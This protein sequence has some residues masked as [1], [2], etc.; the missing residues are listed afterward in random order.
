ME[1]LG[2]DIGGSGIKGAIVNTITGALISK[3]HRIPT[4]KPSNPALMGAVV[5]SLVEHF[6]WKGPVGCSFPTVIVDGK[7]RTEGNLSPGW[8]G[9]KLDDF[10]SEQCGGLQFYVGNDADLAGIAEM[11]LGAGKNKKGKVV[12]ITIG[13]GLGSGVFNNQ[14][15]VSNVELGRIFH[16]DGRPIEFFASDSAR[17][18]ERLSLKEWAKRFDFFLNHVDR[19]LSPNYFIIGGGLSKKFKEFKDDLT[20]DVPVEIA[21]FKNNAGIIGA[22]MFAM[23]NIE[24]G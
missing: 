14:K 17:K 22:A 21:C 5:S 4:P 6:D 12:L 23:E 1:I 2:L 11:K 8:V 18:R 16:T 19:I 15:L 24:N 20:V 7:C 9:V 13:T 10:L 3:R